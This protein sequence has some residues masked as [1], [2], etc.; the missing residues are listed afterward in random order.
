LVQL[1]NYFFVAGS[2][3]PAGQLSHLCIE[4]S[5]Q[6]NSKISELAAISDVITCE[7]EH[8]NVDA[9]DDL[10]K[11]GFQVQP[12]ASTLRIIQDKYKQKRHFE[13]AKLPLAQYLPITSPESV[14]DAGLRL[15]YPFLLKTRRLAY[16]GRGN[17]VVHSEE[18]IDAALGKLGGL[19]DVKGEE[20]LYAEEYVQYD[21]ELAVMVVKAKNGIF[22]YPVVETIQRDNIC[23]LVF[24]PAHIS[25][26]VQVVAVDI[27]KRCVSEFD[28]YGV[29]GVELFLL[30]D[31]SIQVNEIA[32][33]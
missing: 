32:P 3:S 10:E 8:V 26:T 24:C 20:S 16:D 4:G 13:R 33:R 7:I 31:D 23:H 15:G 22:A 5:F 9:L 21:K 18:E 28:G 12:T 27:A 30:H 19:T 29:Y 14:R 17:V 1:S 6:H 25:A 11:R 2:S